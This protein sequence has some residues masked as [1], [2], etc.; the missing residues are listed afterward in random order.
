MRFPSRAIPRTSRGRVAAAA[1]R[2]FVLETATAAV[3]G[4]AFMGA[5]RSGRVHGPV[6]A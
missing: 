1:G 3:Y 6:R 2:G 5:T 4:P